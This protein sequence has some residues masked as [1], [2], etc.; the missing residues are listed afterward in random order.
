MITNNVIETA[1]F[2]QEYPVVISTSPAAASNYWG[3]C[4]SVNYPVN[5]LATGTTCT[6]IP[7]GTSSA[8]AMLS[9][10]S[11]L[12]L[13]TGAWNGTGGYYFSGWYVNGQLVSSTPCPDSVITTSAGTTSIVAEYQPG[14][15]QTVTY[16]TPGTYYFTTPNG[17]TTSTVYQ[18]SVVG[19]GGGGGDGTILSDGASV[20]GTGAGGGGYLVGGVSGLQPGTTIT[21]TVGAGGVYTLSN[22]G[23]SG[24]SSSASTSSFTLNAGGGAG[25][26]S[27]WSSGQYFVSGGIYCAYIYGGSGGSNS[28]SG[29]NINVI[30]N[31][32]GYQGNT[33]GSTPIC[34]GD[35]N[36]GGNSGG[37][38]GTGGSTPYT[39]NSAGN[40]IR[41]GLNG[42]PG[43]PYGGG[44]SG[45]DMIASTDVPHTGGQNGNGY[46]SGGAGASGMVSIS[47]FGPPS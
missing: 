9:S 29:S 16:T 10:G 45:G 4:F 19:A 41:I 42:N 7:Y 40:E 15:Q 21:V 8:T 6:S 43:N 26:E 32:Q 20:P 38:M 34:E 27:A 28:A 22:T 17:T 23:T 1:N 33:T 24:G 18:I 11:Q 31:D 25:G 3:A 37:N 14:S 12:Y 44:G 2:N 39:L 35:N 36:N 47:W 30:T 46:S 5:A 13:C